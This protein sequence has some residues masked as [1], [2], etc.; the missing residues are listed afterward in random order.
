[1]QE[2]GRPPP[3]AGK[4]DVREKEEKNEV[5]RDTYTCMLAGY[6]RT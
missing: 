5:D 1:V 3:G 4:K 6:F 2:L